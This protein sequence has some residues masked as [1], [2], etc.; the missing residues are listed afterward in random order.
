MDAGVDPV[1][2]PAVGAVVADLEADARTQAGEVVAAE[3][4]GV[5]GDSDGPAGSQHRHPDREGG[6]EQLGGAAVAIA[7]ARRGF[8]ARCRRARP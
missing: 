6:L 7:S 8:R 5:P 1:G 3:P 2:E 4:V